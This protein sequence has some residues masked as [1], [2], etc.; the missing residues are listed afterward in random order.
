MF[1][2]VEESAIARYICDSF[3]GI[4]PVTAWGEASF[5]Y[6]PRR[7]LPRGVYFATLKNKDGDN[8]RASDLDRPAV[9]RLNIG[10]SKATYRQ[11]VGPLPARP[12][13]GSVVA[14]GHDFSALDTLLPH[15]VYG[16]MAW[17]SVLNPTPATFDLT[18]PLLDE[19]YGLAVAKFCKRV[20]GA[21]GLSA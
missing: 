7:A 20:S 6:N 3:A 19:A 16:L 13:A 5:F 11:L 21:V 9:F 18:R 14:T 10:I 2:L 1:R 8:D 4:V 17:V 12:S 15:P